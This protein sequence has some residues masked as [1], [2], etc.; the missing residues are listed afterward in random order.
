MFKYEPTVDVTT[1]PWYTWE[2]HGERVY[3][4]CRYCNAPYDA[5]R[6]DHEMHRD[7]CKWWNAYCAIEQEYDDVLHTE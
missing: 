4:N 5:Y 3:G 7:W 2:E 6:D 1:E